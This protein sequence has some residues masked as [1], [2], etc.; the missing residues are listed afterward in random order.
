MSYNTMQIINPDVVEKKRRFHTWKVEQ[1]RRKAAIYSLLNLNKFSGAYVTRKLEPKF[2]ELLRNE[3][4]LPEVTS[5]SVY[6]EYET[7]YL[8][9]HYKLDNGDYDGIF[10]CNTQTR[11][12]EQSELVKNQ[13]NNNERARELQSKLDHLDAAVAAYNRLAEEYAVIHES[14]DGV[15]DDEIPNPDWGLRSSL[16]NAHSPESFVQTIAKGE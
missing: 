10:L 4:C 12:I 14:L 5:V 15:I 16:R 6:T 3:K 7:V 8:N 1:Y 9:V 13:L 2:L 11:R